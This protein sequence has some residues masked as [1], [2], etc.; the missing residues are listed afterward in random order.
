MQINL[1][2]PEI[3]S[4]LNKYMAGLGINTVGKTVTVKF[5]AGRGDS[6]LSAE[7]NIDE[8]GLPDFGPGDDEEVTKPALA[9]VK[10]TKSE[11]TSGTAAE[12]GA[13]ADEAS[14]TPTSLFGG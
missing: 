1:K 7:I 8:A 12:D 3:I 11:V 4:A 6:G 13:K 5:T 2:Q 9:L 10:E 14:P